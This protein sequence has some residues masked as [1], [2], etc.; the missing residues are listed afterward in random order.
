MHIQAMIAALSLVAAGSPA[1]DPQTAPTTAQEP[2]VADLADVE[3]TGRS[4]ERVETFIREVAAPPPGRRLARWH[5]SI[6]VGVSN[7]DRQYAQFMLDR[8]AVIATDV[9]L[10]SGEPGC[11]PN[12]MIIAASD[13]E[14]LAKALVE[15]DPFVFR[16]VQGISDLGEAALERFQVT[17]APVRWWHVS[18]PVMVDTGELATSLDG[19]RAYNPKTGRPEPLVINVRE[20]TRL[21][22]N[23]RDDLDRVTII[24]DVAKV[25]RVGFGPLSDYVAMIALAQVAPDA[26]TSGYDTVLNLFAENADRSLGLT[27][28]DRDY[29]TALYAANDDRARPTQQARDITRAMTVENAPQAD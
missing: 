18:L 26:D 8:I 19:E 29:L 17:D 4:V 21:R 7:L 16:P 1:Q 20:A 25:G 10:D 15:D 2:D 9:G 3:V 23:T 22:A 5:R 27:G 11:R 12:V 6:C 28:W 13:A 14:A 24:I